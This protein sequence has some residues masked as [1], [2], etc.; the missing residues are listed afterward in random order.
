MLATFSF[1]WIPF[2]NIMILITFYE[3]YNMSVSL[4]RVLEA[5]LEPLQ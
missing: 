2:Y 4:D 5:N 3:K 1:Q